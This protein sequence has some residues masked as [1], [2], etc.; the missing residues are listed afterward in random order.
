MVEI[1][2]CKF[3]KESDINLSV[4]ING[5]NAHILI[6]LKTRIGS[7]LLSK[8]LCHIKTPFVRFLNLWNFEVKNPICH[9]NPMIWS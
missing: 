4:K 7:K 5:K 1:Y 3:D 9:N 6:Y 8:G 2:T